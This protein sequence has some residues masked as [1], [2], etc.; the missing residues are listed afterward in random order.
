MP[1]ATAT[2][3]SLSFDTLPLSVDYTHLHSIA[4]RI[5]S[6]ETSHDSVFHHTISFVLSVYGLVVTK[7]NLHTSEHSIIK[8]SPGSKG[9]G[10]VLQLF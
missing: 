6:S 1:R 2:S 9:L 4:S 5:C 10:W 3:S 8:K 7:K